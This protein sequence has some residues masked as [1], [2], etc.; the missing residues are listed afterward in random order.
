MAREVMDQ[1]VKTGKVTRGYMG[2]QVQ[3]VTPSLAR[4]F[5]LPTAAGAALPSIEPGSPAEKA[6]LQPGDVVTA[7][8]G[9]PVADA[10]SLRLRISRTAPGTPVKLTVNRPDGQKEI[11]VNLG[12]LPSQDRD[13]EGQPDL[14]GGAKTPLEGVSV[15]DLDRQTAQ[16]LQLPATVRGVVVTN[17]DVASDAYEAGLR[18]GDVIQS[19]NRRPVTSVREFEAAVGRGQTVLLLVNRGGATRFIAIEPSPSK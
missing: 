13:S 17:V 7:V 2:A 1:L 9:E 4:A 10:N 6:G 11:T 15:D 5:K 12:T 14:R 19:V 16:Q 8:N 3:D 18:R